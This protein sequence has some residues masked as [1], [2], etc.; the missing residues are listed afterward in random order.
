M[1]VDDSSAIGPRPSADALPI[2][3]QRITV[4]RGDQVWTRRIGGGAAQERTPLLILH[5]G[6]G[7][8]HDYLENLEALAS[9]QQQV[10]FYDQLGCGRSDQPDDPARWQLPRFVA[11]VDRVREALGLE[12]VIILGQSWGGML[13]IE[14]ALGQP[15]GLRGLILANS[16]SS[17][18]LWE[19]ET[20]RLRA[21]LSAEV[22]AV[23]DQHE[24]SGTTDSRAYQGALLA[25][26]R[27]HLLRLQHWP[28]SVQRAFERIGQPYGVMW[29]PSEFHITGHLRDWDRT[30]RLHEIPV[31][32]LLIS[33]EFD[34]STPRINQI[35]RDQLP[36]AE[37]RLLAGCSHLAH[38]EAPDTYRSAVNAFL[39][40][41][42][43]H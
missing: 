39:E 36:D 5:G 19:E 37:W 33:G 2:Q 26:Y 43:S 30:E 32:T 38:V 7:V 11:E 41:L 40:R 8:P 24:A 18:A 34:E 35:M 17:A 16:G 13:A 31:P 23:L 20:R 28:E 10:V 22:R 27:R 9:A 15:A 6:P 1:A 3:E 12:S 4:E 25:F 14:Y 21:Q 29:G 42:A